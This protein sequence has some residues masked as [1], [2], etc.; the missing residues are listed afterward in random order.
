MATLE[1]D[2]LDEML[3]DLQRT[4]EVVT[5]FFRKGM[6]E[7]MLLIHGPIRKYP[8]ATEANSPSRRR[9]YQRGYGMKWRTEDG[10]VR[11]IRTSE[12]LGPN[13]TMKVSI[14]PNGVPGFIEGPVVEG[15]E[16][17]KVS[18]VEVVQ[19]EEDQASYHKRR[20]WPIIEDTV[21][22]ASPGVYK[23]FNGIVDAWQKWF[24]RGG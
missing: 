22:K 8:A 7:S 18:Y 16:G 6:T 11:G 19:G 12:R 17:N 14:Y 4:P 5:P 24:Y 9:W 3:R 2:G 23:I 21:E 13:W 1:I 20:G 15:V 10:A